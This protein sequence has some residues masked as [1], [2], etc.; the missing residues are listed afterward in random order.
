M[1]GLGGTIIPARTTVLDNH[2]Y[3]NSY[4]SDNFHCKLYACSEFHKIIIVSL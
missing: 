1:E 2:N 3:S 4:S